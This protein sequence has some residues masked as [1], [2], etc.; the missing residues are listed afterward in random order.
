MHCWQNT[1]SRGQLGMLFEQIGDRRRAV[2]LYE[3]ADALYPND[4][5][6]VHRLGNLYLALTRAVGV[7]SEVVN[8]FET[9]VVTI[10]SVQKADKQAHVAWLRRAV[11]A[12]PT[13]YYTVVNLANALAEYACIVWLHYLLTHIRAGRAC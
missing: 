12:D 9:A 8:A 13:E 1:D 2:Q 11:A 6:V 5:P 4:K 3:R 7:K 10:V